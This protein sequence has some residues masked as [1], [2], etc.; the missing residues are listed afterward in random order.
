MSRHGRRR[1]IA[2]PVRRG[3]HLLHLVRT[4]GPGWKQKAGHEDRWRLSAQ[5]PRE[6]RDRIRRAE[7]NRGAYGGSRR[8]QQE[9]GTVLSPRCRSEALQ[10]KVVLG[11]GVSDCCPCYRSSS[12][13]GERPRHSARGASCGTLLPRADPCQAC[14]ES[15]LARGIC[16]SDSGELLFLGTSL[17]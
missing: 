9:A 15:T 8:E 1:D 7:S 16:S 4:G 6:T 10:G 14:Q 5:D 13:H 11:G 17:W 3:F 12:G 2:L